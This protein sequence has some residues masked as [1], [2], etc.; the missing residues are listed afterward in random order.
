MP[1]NHQKWTIK[2]NDTFREPIAAV[3]RK[4]HRSPSQQIEHWL[5]RTLAA[6]AIAESKARMQQQPGQDA[7]TASLMKIN[8]DQ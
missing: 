8:G 6:N 3:A 7:L 2:I 5:E 4:N 1:A